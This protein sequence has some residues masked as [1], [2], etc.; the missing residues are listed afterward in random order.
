[1]GPGHSVEV[2]GHGAGLSVRCGFS[3]NFLVGSPR[4]SAGPQGGVG[5]RAW[6]RRGPSGISAVGSRQGAGDPWAHGASAGTGS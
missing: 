5:D 6:P 4:G 3:E 2:A 1:M